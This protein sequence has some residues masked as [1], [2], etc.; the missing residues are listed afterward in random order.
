MARNPLHKQRQMAPNVKRGRA[1]GGGMSS[2]K[3]RQNDGV[4]RPAPPRGPGDTIK[5]KPRQNDGVLRPAP[6][7]G[8]GD[9]I[10][11]KP[12]GTMR[13]GKTPRRRSA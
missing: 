7:R 12:G 11:P 8:P 13:R 5:P 2:G 6:P 10:K 1:P 3:P 4:L 9:T